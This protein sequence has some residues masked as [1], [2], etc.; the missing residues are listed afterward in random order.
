L[1]RLFIWIIGVCCLLIT[2][3]CMKKGSTYVV[4]EQ[5]TLRSDDTRPFGA[6]V[7]KTITD[8]L[9]HGQQTDVNKYHF[10]SWYEKEKKAKVI[11]R[12]QVYVLLSPGVIAW[13][14]EVE[15]MR[16]FVEQ[17]NTLLLV[18][19][20]MNKEMQEQL[21]LRIIDDAMLLPFMPVPPMR[22]TW[23]QLHDTA[24][25][26][27]KQFSYFYSPMAQ[28]LSAG[29]Q[30][31]SVNTLSTNDAGR[32][33]ALRI[34]MGRGQLIVATNARSFS[35]YFLLSQN[36][37]YYL[38][39]LY[40]YLPA[41]PSRIV[42]DDFYNRNLYRQPE[43]YSILSALLSIPALRWA[44][45]ILMVAGLLW[46]LSN[47]RRKQKM[48]PVLAPNTNTT[49]SFVQTIAQLYYNKAD[50]ANIARK[51]TTHLSDQLRSRYYLPPSLSQTDWQIVLEQKA[52]LNKEEADQLAMLM[53]KAQE[54]EW[55][56]FTEKDLLQ[57]HWLAHKATHGGTKTI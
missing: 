21:A 49:V 19:D 57:M 10:Q 17:G 24:R 7:S 41:Y 30:Y 29:S 39:G 25:L 52:L 6:S 22:D 2:E 33:A 42:W 56:D 20:R 31:L 28:R 32:P 47:L 23:L 45:W 44:F 37:L 51:I 27:D 5:Y 12:E 15:A 50:H 16:E 1:N 13:E 38:L 9:F 53:Q 40:G 34:R 43:G 4:D 8:Q 46:V 26:S 18:T 11:K 14:N 36:N 35:N 3:G 48:I 54:Q 55:R